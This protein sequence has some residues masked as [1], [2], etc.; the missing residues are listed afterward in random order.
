M[1]AEPAVGARAVPSA[2]GLVRPRPRPG[3]AVRLLCFPHAGGGAAAYADWPDGLGPDIEVC[4]VQLPGRE[5]RIGLSPFQNVEELVAALEA[6]VGAE[7]DR[8]FALFGHSMGAL[9]A[10]EF[11]RRLREGGRPMPVHLFV[12]ARPAPHLPPPRSGAHLLSDD[13]LLERVRE[14]GGTPPEVLADARLMRLV[15]PV[16]RADFAV[17]DGYLH[18]PGQP[19]DCPVSALG[20][21]ADAEISPAAL[22]GWR[23]HT[24]GS[25]RMRLFEGGHF[26]LRDEPEAVLRLVRDTLSAR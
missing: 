24:T 8:P 25:F 13:R 16:L 1:P 22:A 6:S 26:Y 2:I 5:A 12:S 17:N 4:A 19:L 14:L 11:A 21:R 23:T 15:L 3:A 9:A 7:L 18:R 20:G 10:F